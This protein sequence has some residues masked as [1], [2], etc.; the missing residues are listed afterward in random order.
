MLTYIPLS[1][2]PLTCQGLQRCCQLLSRRWLQHDASS[3]P[4]AQPDATPHPRIKPFDPEGLQQLPPSFRGKPCHGSRQQCEAA[5]NC[6]A[7]DGDR[8]C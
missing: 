7:Y 5:E 6:R 2:F 1:R 8:T 3:I 4:I